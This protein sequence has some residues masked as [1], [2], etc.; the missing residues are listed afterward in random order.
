MILGTELKLI[1]QTRSSKVQ[2]IDVSVICTW[3]IYLSSDFDVFLM[4]PFQKMIV[5][6]TNTQCVEQI[7]VS[8]IVLCQAKYCIETCQ[9]A[10]AVSCCASYSNALPIETLVCQYCVEN[11]YFNAT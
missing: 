1:F 6:K 11:L 8:S 2:K 9:H 4:N 3:R 7:T 5:E 10:V